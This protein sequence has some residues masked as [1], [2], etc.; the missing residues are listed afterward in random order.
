MKAKQSDTLLPMR[1][2]AGRSTTAPGTGAATSCSPRLTPRCSKVAFGKM[3][4]LESPIARTLTVVVFPAIGELRYIII[5]IIIRAERCQAL[6]VPGRRLA[7]AR[8]APF[9][10]LALR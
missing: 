2:S 5:H 1:L 3:T 8:R 9:D 10:D 6:A 7:M 4:P